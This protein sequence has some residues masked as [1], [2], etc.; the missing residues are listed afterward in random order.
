MTRRTIVTALSASVPL[1]VAAAQDAAP[2][3]RRG[4]LKQA[5]CPGV[6]GR[7]MPLEDRCRH[8]ARLGVWGID[9]IGPKDWPTLKKYGLIPTM[10]PGGAGSIRDGLNRVENHNEARF[11]EILSACAANGVPNMIGMAGEKKGQADE[12]GIENMVKFLNKVKAELED[13]QVTLCIEYLNSKVNHPDYAFDNMRYGVEVCKRVSSPRVKILFD[14]YHAQIMEGDVIRTIR[15]NLQHIGHFH[16]AG[17]PGRHETDDTQEMN[18]KGIARAIAELP[19]NG[20]VSH[21][22]SP[23]RDPLTSLE[24]TLTLFEVV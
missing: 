15:N 11:R 22:Y 6:F 24:E 17:N 14:I 13:K 12:E 10:A 9:L 19:Y 7:Q 21:E 8:A 2:R 16:T 20:F 3:R 18:Y 4:K 5:V 23:V 1:V